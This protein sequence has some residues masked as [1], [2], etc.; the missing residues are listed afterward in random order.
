MSQLEDVRPEP[1]PARPRPRFS[2]LVTLVC[3]VVVAIYVSAP[4]GLH[5]RDSS[6]IEQLERPE[7]S[8]QRLVSRELDLDEALRQGPRWEWRVYRA[9]SGNEEPIREARTWYEELAAALDSDAVALPRAIVLGESGDTHEV[10]DL[11]ARWSGLH[12]SARRAADW[13]RAAYLADPPDAAAGRAL[14]AEIGDHLAP[15]WFA[16]TLVRRIAVRIGDASARQ[17]ADAAMV[18][19]GRV[20]M[21]RQ[22]LLWAMVIVL[23]VAGSLALARM[24]AR[25]S[26]GRIA[27]APLPP[28]WPAADGYALFVRALG[29]P[30]AI[31]LVVFYVFR[32]EAPLDGVLMMAAE[33]PVFWWVLSYLRARDGSMRAA[34]GLV[35]RRDGW[36]P[37]VGV[38]LVLIAAAGVGDSLIDAAGALLGFK[39]HWA[40]GFAEDLLW[41]PRWGFVV[42]AF[43]ATV[44]APIIEELT[45]RGLLYGTLRTR[46]GAWPAALLSAAI[47][48][49]PHGYAAAG[50][51]SVLLSGVLWAVAY[52][53]TRSLLPG[54]LAHAAN[55]IMSTLWVAALLRW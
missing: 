27:D 52:E 32:R 13:L 23:F 20:L 14:I 16:D 5:L 12:E 53:R 4:L 35:P 34:F 3:S 42:T 7:A 48:A 15:D 9:V 8:L 1:A 31:T 41:Q 18:A 38:T 30:Q 39:A 45:F 19:R 25:R 40:D 43:H 36:P 10:G 51:L 24:L 49:L 28:D 54:L 47:F 33:L 55:N 11:V 50:S 22:R 46:L 2:I 37:L 26:P 21:E 29:A 6:P 44:W 17:Q